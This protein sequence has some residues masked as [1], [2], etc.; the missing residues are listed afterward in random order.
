MNGGTTGKREGLDR[1]VGL[2]YNKRA[3]VNLPSTKVGDLKSSPYNPRKITAKQLEMLGK[4]MKEFGDLSGVVVNIKT[5]HVVGGHQRLKHLDPAWKI[6]KETC[7]DSVGTAAIG[8]IVTPFGAWTYREVDWP[9]RREKAA[10]IA[11]NRHGGE[12]DIP[13]LKDLL[14]ELN[15]GE[16]DMVLTGFSEDELEKL[17]DFEKNG[18]DGDVVPSIPKNAITKIGDLWMLGEHRLLCGDSTNEKDVER[19]FGGVIADMVLTDPP[20]GVDC[21]GKTKAALKIKNDQKDETKLAKLVKNSFDLAQKVSR[22][23]AYWYA[24]VPSASSFLIFASDWK[25]RGILRQILVWAKDSMVL[26]YTEYHYQHDLILF[27]WVEGKRYKNSDRTRTT[28]W[29]YP[30]SKASVGHPTVKP[31]EL[32]KRAIID[33]SRKGDVVYDPFL[34]SGTSIIATEQLGRK[35][36][37]LELDP[38]YCDVIIK[39]WENFTEKKAELTK[40][41]NEAIL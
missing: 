16:F 9:E 10:N 27:G 41:E 4:A 18:M 6:I 38:L 17:I 15:D 24:T 28:L 39:R 40:S 34:G 14:L 1:T 12:F 11:A 22:G 30:R 33:G 19:L 3:R 20:Y 23:G 8:H 26:G 25:A 29:E 32:W 7:K 35:C 5:G 36:Y 13:G 37:G 2:N 21:V 31:V